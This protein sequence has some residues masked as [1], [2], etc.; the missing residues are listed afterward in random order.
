MYNPDSNAWCLGVVAQ[1]VS[2]VLRQSGIMHRTLHHLLG[3]I[4]K[5]QLAECDS[6]EVLVQR[7]QAWSFE[8]TLLLT[9]SIGCVRAV[10]FGDARAILWLDVNVMVPTVLAAGIACE[11]L[12]RLI[13]WAVERRGWAGFPMVSYP[14]EHPLGTFAGAPRTFRYK[15]T[16]WT[17]YGRHPRAQ[18][19]C[20]HNVCRPT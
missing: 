7:S 12:T 10:S 17:I 19:L 14:A 11:L 4:G 6:L 5:Q 13:V 18:P 20:T 8:P 1:L 16:F 3:R 15:K 2:N 9:L